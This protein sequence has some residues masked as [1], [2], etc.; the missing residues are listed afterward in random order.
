MNIDALKAVLQAL[1]GKCYDD[2]ADEKSEPEDKMASAMED[3]QDMGDDM[4][5]EDDPMGM[6]PEETM[7]ADKA[8]ADEASPI[9]SGMEDEEDPDKAALRQFFKPKKPAPS[10]P[11]T[12]VMIAIDKKKP[13]PGKKSMKDLMNG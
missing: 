3:T 9:D 11:G 8:D 2:M 6:D 5:D 10:R 4:A 12:A 1:S 13:I 7:L